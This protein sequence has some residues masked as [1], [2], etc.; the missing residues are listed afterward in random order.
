MKLIF[1]SRKRGK[2]SL[3]RR[4]IARAENFFYHLVMGRN[5]RDAWE[6]AKKTF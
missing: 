2:K 4:I 1:P 6:I 3:L 5:I